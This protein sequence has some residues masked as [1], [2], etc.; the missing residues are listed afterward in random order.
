MPI[1]SGAP[2]PRIRDEG[3]PKVN[4]ASVE[5]LAHP[6]LDRRLLTNA[7]EKEIPRQIDSLLESRSQP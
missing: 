6:V 7:V 2:G 1:E 4:A 5:I 3:V